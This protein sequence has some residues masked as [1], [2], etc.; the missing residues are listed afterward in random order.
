MVVAMVVVVMVV[1]ACLIAWTKH[2]GLDVQSASHLP[3]G[4]ASPHRERSG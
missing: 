4:S 3:K 2:L 1:V